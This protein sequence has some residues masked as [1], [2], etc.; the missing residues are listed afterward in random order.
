VADQVRRARGELVAHDAPYD[1]HGESAR[2]HRILDALEQ[3]RYDALAGETVSLADA[4]EAQGHL[5]GALEL[6]RCAYAVAVALGS[7][8]RAVD[9]ARLAGRLLRRQANWEEA[10]RWFEV[11]REIAD[12]A[13]LPDVAARALVGLAGIKKET[14]NLPAAREAFQD[15]LTWAERSQSRDAIA[16]V[17]HGLLGLEQVAGNA[18]RG[19]H[20][21][22]IAVAT[23]EDEQARMRCLAGLAGALADFGDRE[24]AEDA[25]SLVAHSSNEA[26]YRMYAHD[27][28]AYLAALRGDV[29]AF[30]EHAAK[31]DALNWQ[32]AS[33]S[34][35]AEILYYR[36]LSYRALDQHDRAEE[37]LR[38][39]VDFAGE[40]KFGRVLFNAEQ[41]LRDRPEASPE[42]ETPAPAAPRELREGLRAMRH[43]L[44]G[45]AV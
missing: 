42:P 14:G 31:C 3:G 9:A 41:A 25:W 45:V 4:V 1:D 38:R 24:A 23:Y 36:G 2:W 30:E 37:W 28:L 11:T 13:D 32:S 21:G 5:H 40:H 10:R 22:W 26:Y 15:A 27:A 16:L 6:Y 43:E 17:H 20:H 12:A 33:H 8:Q 34:A 18:A 19:L 35:K 44:V 7:P 29:G 39:A